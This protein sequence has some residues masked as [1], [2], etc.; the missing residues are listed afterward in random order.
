MW[1]CSD[2]LHVVGDERFL[3]HREAGARADVRA[4]A[5]AHAVLD[6]AGHGENA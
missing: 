3:E 6:V 4:H 1:P 2:H 5:E